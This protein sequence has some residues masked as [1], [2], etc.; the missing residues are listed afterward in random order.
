MKGT[1]HAHAHSIKHE[2]DKT[3]HKF[4]QGMAAGNASEVGQ[5]YTTDAQFMAPNEH[6]IVGRKNIEKAIAGYIHQGFTYYKVTSST[7]YGN[8]G[9]VGVESEYVLAKKDGSDKDIGKSIQL[10]KQEENEWKIFR[11]CFN[12]NEPSES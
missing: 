6:S 10:W 1:N 8:N 5:C 2:I 11:D 9:I 7:V 3:V 12:S 4:E